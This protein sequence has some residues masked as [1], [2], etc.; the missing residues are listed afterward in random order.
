M[1]ANHSDWGQ[2]LLRK[3]RG[4]HALA[5]IPQAASTLTTSKTVPRLRVHDR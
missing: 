1:K 3:L 4:A 2:S 5:G